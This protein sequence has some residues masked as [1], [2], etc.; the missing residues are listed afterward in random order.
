[1]T[2]VIRY[3]FYAFT[4]LGYV[5]YQLLW[6]R[7]TAF[8]LLYPL[9]AAS[10]AIGAYATLPVSSPWKIYDYFRALLFVTWWPCRFLPQNSVLHAEINSSAVCAIYLHDQTKKESSRKR[11]DCQ[12][13]MNHT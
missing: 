7:Y 13:R 2:E 10:E 9:G 5:P 4:L 11:K 6:L 1:M 12:K 8:Y 3:P